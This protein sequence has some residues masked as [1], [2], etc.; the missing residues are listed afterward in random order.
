M[1]ALETL[2]HE[3]RVI[4]IGLEMLDAMAN[5]MEH[6]SPIDLERIKTLLDFFAV[7]AD[8]CHHAKEEDI[9]FPILRERGIPKEGGP[10]G[11]MLYEHE[12][13][14]LFQQ[15]MRENRWNAGI[16]PKRASSL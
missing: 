6:G 11:V 4:E 1:Q 13:G 8:H 12:E 10:I 3:H 7:F 2:K 16:L 9:F 15:Q 5:R 14:R